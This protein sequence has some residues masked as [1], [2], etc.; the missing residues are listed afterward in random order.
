MYKISIERLRPSS[1]TNRWCIDYPRDTDLYNL[2]RL[3][4][5][6]VD[7]QGWALFPKDIKATPFIRINK[8]SH[9]FSFNMKRSDVVKKILNEQPEGH[10]QLECGFHFKLPLTADSLTFG[11]KTNGIDYDYAH[12]S[13]SGSLKVLEGD[14][15]WLFLD[16]DANRSVD[17]YRGKRLLSAKELKAWTAYLDSFYRL[18]V[19]KNIRHSLLIAPAKEMVLSEYY[20]FKRGRKTPIEQLLKK[21]RAHHALSYPVQ[22]F[23]QAEERPFRI[24][25][26]HWAPYGAMLA[27]VEVLRKLG[28]DTEGARALFAQ[29]QYK[30][31]TVIGD[32]GNKIYP[33]R[34]AIERVLASFSYRKTV[35]YDNQ[36]ANFGRVMLLANSTALHPAKC[37]LFGSSSSYT[38]LDYFS[39]LFSEIVFIHSAGNIDLNL[40]EIEQPDYIVAQTNARFVVIAPILGYDLHTVIKAKLNE[41]TDDEK[42]DAITKSAQ[43]LQK[44]NTERTEHYHRL[45]TQQ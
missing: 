8:E 35:I 5:E 33:P 41:L 12:F 24:T 30:E 45:M 17:Q 37:V 32:L 3:T 28:V 2:A 29:D 9:Y 25:D 6:G 16:N 26:T 7:F 43:W 10:G 40:I 11:F 14:K 1:P 18:A 27:A 44:T 21:T 39:R 19:S 4:N 36:L 34:S 22:A 38:M 20:P 13:V 42:Q 15:G 31:S 23:K